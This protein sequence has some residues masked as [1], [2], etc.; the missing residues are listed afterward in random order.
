MY[1]ISVIK[2]FKATSI[3]NA[4]ITI[5]EIAVYYN[6]ITLL[7]FLRISGDPGRMT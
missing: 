6:V 1:I 2:L 7:I 4:N 3:I 5:T